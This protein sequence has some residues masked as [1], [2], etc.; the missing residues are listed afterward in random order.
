[1]IKLIKISVLVLFSFTIL[2]GLIYPLIITGFAHLLFPYQANGS[3]IIKNSDVVGSA[4]IGQNFD[5]Q[6]YFW[7]RLSATGEQP[8]N[9]SASSGLNLSSTNPGLVNNT[10]NRIQELKKVDANNPIPIPIDLVSS[11]ASG[12]D[13]D[14]SVAAALYQAERVSRF[15]GLSVDQVFELIKAHTKNRLFGFFGEPRVNVLELNLALD[16]LQ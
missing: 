10:K 5:Q 12:L 3:V 16:E 8:Y 1:M 4:L 13:P 14:I 6:Q 7:G 11:S 9:A 15:R 2:T